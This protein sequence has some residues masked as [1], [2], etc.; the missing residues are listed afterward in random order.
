MKDKFLFKGKV[1]SFDTKN[2]CTA[3]V[4]P[5]FF[6][7]G[8]KVYIKGKVAKSSSTNE[9]LKDKVCVIKWKQVQNY[10]IYNSIKDYI[11]GTK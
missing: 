9:W 5:I 7:I 10:I 2:Y 3:L 6:K 4:N 8:K 1:V 11:K